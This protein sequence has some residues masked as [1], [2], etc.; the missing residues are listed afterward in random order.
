MHK[1][2]EL[3]L[4]LTPK[5]LA[6]VMENNGTLVIPWAEGIVWVGSLSPPSDL[7]SDQQTHLD[8]T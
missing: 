8:L 3:E 7:P 5:P 6:Q 1:V 2:P 4:G